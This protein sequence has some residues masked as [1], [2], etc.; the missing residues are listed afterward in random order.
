MEKKSS[1]VSSVNN[2]IKDIK[3]LDLIQ[4][5]IQQ[6]NQMLDKKKNNLQKDFVEKKILSYPVKF[7]EIPH[8]RDLDFRLSKPELDKLLKEKLFWYPESKFSKGKINSFAH[9]YLKASEN[10]MPVYITTDSILHAFNLSLA[11]IINNIEI[12]RM[13]EILLKLLETVVLGIP[14]IKDNYI[15]EDDY[16]VEL[17]KN[18]EIYYNVAY[19]LLTYG[20]PA[21]QENNIDDPFKENNETMIN[22]IKKSEIF[23][24]NIKDALEQNNNID[25]S[26]LIE[27]DP[28]EIDQYEINQIQNQEIFD[29]GS[30][31]AL[32]FENH[33]EN[34]QNF[35]EEDLKQNEYNLVE[36]KLIRVAW[37]NI[38]KSIGSVQK[39]S[40]PE[41]I[42][43]IVV[44][45]IIGLI[46]SEEVGNFT[47]FGKIISI[48]FSKFKSR[49]KLYDYQPQINYYRCLMWLS[50]VEFDC[51]TEIQE[52]WILTRVLYH[53]FQESSQDLLKIF[54]EAF[55]LIG[56]ESSICDF[57]DVFEIGSN[58]NIRS[59]LLY[60][61]Q[62]LS[63]VM[64]ILQRTQEKIKSNFIIPSTSI[65]LNYL[66]LMI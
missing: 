51:K 29:F 43:E 24:K 8:H 52:I 12:G 60:Q 7:N 22:E 10:D 16:V 9:F 66:V 18:A 4:R 11:G 48:D 35:E 61:E 33:K 30:I 45:E 14:K 62:K 55:C 64:A 1:Q 42:V 50:N 38:A 49:G 31:L 59:Y 36:N 2:E 46:D 3:Y 40:N 65:F 34:G 37:D 27:I 26:L 57:E 39:K 25:A 23:E 47:L 53:C 58:L 19:R 15:E 20:I 17:L 6:F 54:K 56:G 28:I 32:D 13:S 41:A 63:L 44:D 5:D 21:Y